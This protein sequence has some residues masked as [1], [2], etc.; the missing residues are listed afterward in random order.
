MIGEAR[1]L[2]RIGLVTPSIGDYGELLQP[3]GLFAI[4]APN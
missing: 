2:M 1:G 4:R 3:F